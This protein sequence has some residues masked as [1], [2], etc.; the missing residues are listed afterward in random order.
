MLFV[1]L[2]LYNFFNDNSSTNKKLTYLSKRYATNPALPIS[3]SRLDVLAGKYLSI[4]TV[5]FCISNASLDEKLEMSADDSTC[6][7]PSILGFSTG[8]LQKED[9]HFPMPK[10][11]R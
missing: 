1:S 3:N 4:F 10:K 7:T 2:I 11:A 6:N 5:I 9:V 8:V